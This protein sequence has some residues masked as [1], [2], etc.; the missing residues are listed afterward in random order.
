MKI[1]YKT[2]STDHVA[3]WT[4]ATHHIDFNTAARG[5]IS[6]ENNL[7]WM[8]QLV[9]TANNVER[10]WVVLRN[11]VPKLWHQSPKIKML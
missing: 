9:S 2:F 11:Y 3:L 5:R 4:A 10:I 1:L 8:Q 7:F 6:G